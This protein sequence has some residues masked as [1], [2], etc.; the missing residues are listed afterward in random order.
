MLAVNTEEEAPGF[1]EALK[2]FTHSPKSQN[3]DDS[4]LRFQLKLADL[5]RVW[6]K[7]LQHFSRNVSLAVAWFPVAGELS[8]PQKPTVTVSLTYWGS[9]ETFYSQTEPESLLMPGADGCFVSWAVLSS[10]SG[11]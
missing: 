9:L 6:N 1:T 2:L 5:T 8:S 3:L 10:S 11:L 4:W 7:L